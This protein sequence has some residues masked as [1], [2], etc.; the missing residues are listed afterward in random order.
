M[1][2]EQRVIETSQI[3]ANDDD[4]QE[5]KTPNDGQSSTPHLIVVPEQPKLSENE[6]KKIRDA[7]SEYHDRYGY[8]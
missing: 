6:R 4:S 7:H 1:W 5:K 2:P 3:D 8:V